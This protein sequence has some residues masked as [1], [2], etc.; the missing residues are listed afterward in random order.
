[1]VWHVTQLPARSEQLLM[2]IAFSLLFLIIQV[3]VIDRIKY[4]Y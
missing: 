4:I 1:M 3:I 2:C